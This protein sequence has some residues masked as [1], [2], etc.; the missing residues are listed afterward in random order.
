MEIF[1]DD[2]V[3]LLES[4]DFLASVD[5][6]PNYLNQ[7]LKSYKKAVHPSPKIPPHGFKGHDLEH[8]FYNLVNTDSVTPITPVDLVL[9]SE[10]PKLHDIRPGVYSS[11]LE[12]PKHHLLVPQSDPILVST[13]SPKPLEYKQEEP[14]RLKNNKY[15][16]GLIP[17]AI[18]IQINIPPS[19]DRKYKESDSYREQKHITVTGKPGY[20]SPLNDGGHYESTPA[21][22]YESTPAPHYKSTPAPHYQSTTVIPL[23]PALPSY[24]PTL[25][26][27]LP[28][29]NPSVTPKVPAYKASF[30]TTTVHPHLLPHHPHP[31][32]NS[33][34][35][36]HKSYLPPH[37]QPHYET[38]R[39][40]TYEVSPTPHHLI[41]EY[42]PPHADYLPPS[43]AVTVKPHY[44]PPVKEYLPPKLPSYHE[45]SPSPLVPGYKGPSKS[46]LPPSSDYVPPEHHH[47]PDHHPLSDYHPP[48]KEYLPPPPPHHHSK[49]GYEP[50]SK[51]YLP[52][53]HKDH[54]HHHAKP[55]YEPPSKEYLP[56]PHEDHHPHAKPGYEPPSKEYLPPPRHHDHHDHH[57]PHV[58]SPGYH[59][60]PPTKE[61]LP[62]A[63]YI[64]PPPEV[65]T[66]IE[67]NP[68]GLFS[69]PSKSYL[70]PPARLE[71]GLDKKYVPPPPR[72]KDAL[73]VPDVL[74][75]HIDSPRGDVDHYIPPKT[76]NDVP[77]NFIRPDDILP[78]PPDYL[79]VEDIDFESINF[80]DLDDL[81]DGDN[82]EI[83]LEDLESLGLPGLE[84]LGLNDLTSVDHPFLG[85]AK[86]RDGRPKS[87]EK[88]KKNRNKEK[89]TL[90]DKDK[91]EKLRVGGG[92]GKIGFPPMP[93]TAPDNRDAVPIIEQLRPEVLA[94]LRK[95]QAG[96][97]GGAKAGFIPGKAGVDYPDFR[98]IPATDFTCENF[99]LPGFYADTFTS[100]QVRYE[101][102]IYD[103]LLL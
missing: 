17:H 97:G 29:Y 40:P 48:S 76:L 86:F 68:L 66:D 32:S 95:A 101:R 79:D 90:K 84:N 81:D 99:I 47:H 51:E 45:T 78:P 85:L 61:Y 64:P 75:S 100:C 80:D 74:N 82:V 49:P 35:V 28:K 39:P 14:Q 57:D 69:P 71:S 26:P 10:K 31:P 2:I 25:T 16:S 62:P 83:T 13:I 43:S 8:E 36:P 7:G 23:P 24:N 15:F 93:T 96:G 18:N 27:K 59:Y 65:I 55:G 92:K 46:Y 42:Q 37:P 89:I 50:P 72:S 21:P 60:D 98:S 102:P 34:E 22:H 41:R 19:D 33:Y 20:V 77:K 63:D 6:K 67:G 30:S 56:P 38:P 5:E 44:E 3:P 52:P 87:D 9:A 103:Y 53:S 1:L 73:S 58:K 11:P 91:S 88:R 12:S 70:P 4:D 54:Q 94:Q